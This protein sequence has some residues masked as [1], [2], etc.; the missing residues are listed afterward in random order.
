ML[1]QRQAVGPGL[2]TGSVGIRNRRADRIFDV[3]VVKFIHHGQEMDID[4]DMVNGFAVF[5]RRPEHENRFPLIL[6]GG[7][8]TGTRRMAC[9]LPARLPPGHAG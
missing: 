4:I 2:A 3:E 7:H 5:P 9:A 6:T 1:S 8:H